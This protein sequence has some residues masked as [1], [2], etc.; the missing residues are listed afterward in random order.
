MDNPIQEG[1]EHLRVTLSSP[2]GLESILR[3]SYRR[4]GTGYEPLGSIGVFVRDVPL[5]LDDEENP[6]RYPQ[7]QLRCSRVSSVRGRKLGGF[8]AEIELQADIRLSSSNPN[9]LDSHAI[10]F[11][12]AM[13][14]ILQSLAGRWS[15]RIVYDGQFKADIAAVRP[16]GLGFVK[17]LEFKLVV[18]ALLSDSID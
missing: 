8:A 1:L 17:Q 18:E 2:Q 7:I 3:A 11:S 10:A 14:T 9:G 6:S 16:G 5:R 12:Q 4:Q 13:A 15:S